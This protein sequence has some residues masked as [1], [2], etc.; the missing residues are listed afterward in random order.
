MDWKQELGIKIEQAR[1]KKGWTQGNLASQVH[2]HHNTIGLFERGERVPDFEQLQR[3]AGAL[4][5]DHF[6]VGENIRIDFAANGSTHPPA[7]SQQ[8]ELQFDE[9]EGV[10]VRIESHGQGILIKRLPA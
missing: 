9:Q 4:G 5:Q 2:L 7:T 8:L 10:N 1:R 6:Y 3:L